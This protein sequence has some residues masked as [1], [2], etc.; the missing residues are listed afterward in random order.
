M[1]PRSAG[2]RGRGSA[3]AV[4]IC[5]AVSAP[6]RRW[7][8]EMTVSVFTRLRLPHEAAVLLSGHAG[9]RKEPSTGRCVLQP[10]L[11]DSLSKKKKSKQHE[12]KK[13]LMSYQAPR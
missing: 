5:A 10:S 6:C 12:N 4:F 13:V 9:G 3:S 1:V 7:L 11:H 2:F 8:R